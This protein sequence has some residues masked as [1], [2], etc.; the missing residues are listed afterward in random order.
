MSS[1]IKVDADLHEVPP[2][3]S[4]ISN[5]AIL[6]SPNDIIANA[7]KERCGDLVIDRLGLIGRKDS[8]F[9]DG[10]SEPDGANMGLDVG[11][12]LLA[13]KAPPIGPEGFK[14]PKPLA[15]NPSSAHKPF[16]STSPRSTKRAKPQS[17]KLQ[18]STTAPMKSRPNRSFSYN[19][20][21]SSMSTYARPKVRLRSSSA[22]YARPDYINPFLIHQRGR[23]FGSLEGALTDFESPFVEADEPYMNCISPTSAT[24]PAPSLSE[25]DTESSSLYTEK[26]EALSNHIPATVIDWTSPSTRRREYEEIDKSCRGV[27]GLWR[28][29]APRCCRTNSR[30]KFYDGTDGSDVGSVRRYRL[31]LREQDDENSQAG[32]K[33]PPR[34]SLARTKSSW[35]YFRE[36]GRNGNSRGGVK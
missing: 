28:R 35:N 3:S 30:L 9:C 34:P 2:T 17:S 15:H 36:L 31:D 23:V 16:I 32:G 14:P 10:P 29:F 19:Q 13:T 1:I 25:L 7:E 18:R 12:P 26:A 21:R 11:K 22:A 33:K 24:V 6:N 5:T 27:R 20:E 4:M 8:G